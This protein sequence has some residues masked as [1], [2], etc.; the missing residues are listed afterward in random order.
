[1][2]A[3]SEHKDGSLQTENETETVKEQNA[4]VPSNSRSVLSNGA[5]VSIGNK[6][7]VMLTPSSEAYRQEMDSYLGRCIEHHQSLLK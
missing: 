1:V 6:E 4:Q 3:D 2:T 5:V 7:N